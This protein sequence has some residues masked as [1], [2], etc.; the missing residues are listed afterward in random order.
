M[1][2]PDLA[3]VTA[4]TSLTE[5]KPPALQTAAISDSGM[6]PDAPGL[7]A[8]APVMAKPG[9]LASPNDGVAVKS[10]TTTTRTSI[11]SDTSKRK[12]TGKKQESVQEVSPPLEESTV[13]IA[14]VENKPVVEERKDS[15]Q[16]EQK[17]GWAAFKESLKKGRAERVCSQAEIALNQCG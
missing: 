2:S 11:K 6:Q 12:S 13:A 1:L 10:S 3:A 9:E 7:K 14:P 17:S 8:V 15:P 5:P 16:G 4:D